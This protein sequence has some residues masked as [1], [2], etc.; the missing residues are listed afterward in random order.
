[1][2][3]R[4]ELIEKIQELPDGPLLFLARCLATLR[5]LRPYPGWYFGISENSTELRVQLRRA[6]WNT[7][8]ER[9][10]QKPTACPWYH[11]SRIYLYLG[12]DVSRA[13]Y[14]GG[15]IE[16]NEFAFIDSVLQEDMVMI[17]VGANDGLFTIFAARRVGKKGRVLAFEP[18]TREFARL[19]ANIRM[20]R[21]RNVKAFA[22]AA[23]NETGVAQLKICEYGHEGQNT[24]GEFPYAVKQAEV[25]VVEICRLDE[26]LQIEKLQRLDVMK[27]DVEGAEYK[28]LQG[29][30]ETIRKFRPIILL[31]LLDKALRHQGNSAAQVVQFLLDLDYNI[32]DFSTI[33]GRLVVSD[34]KTHS[35]NIVASPR[36]LADY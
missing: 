34:L 3:N 18:S 27:I 15:C 36:R 25:Q 7:C 16:P 28:V 30:E 2:L 12:N 24:L 19:Q 14:I 20:N 4:I 21:L 9:R 5:P 29:S 33:S 22:K 11:R 13:T 8:R 35:D 32:Y 17:D 1:M 26:F 31:E 10:L 23:S 6:I